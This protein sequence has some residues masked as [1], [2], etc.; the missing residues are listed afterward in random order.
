MKGK[1]KSNFS[2]IFSTRD[3]HKERCECQTNSKIS[4]QILFIPTY[5]V[6]SGNYYQ[7]D[8]AAVERTGTSAPA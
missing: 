4:V 8:I 5:H 7:I 2:H 3:R 1:A 6:I